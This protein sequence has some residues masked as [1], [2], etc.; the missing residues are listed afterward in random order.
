MED[1]I[2]QIL[3]KHKLPLKKR[4]EVLADLLLL[5]GVRESFKCEEEIL[6]TGVKCDKQCQICWKIHVRDI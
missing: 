6:V 5:L 2:Y 3:K 4:Q 1:K